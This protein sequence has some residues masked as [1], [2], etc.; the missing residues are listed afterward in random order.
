MKSL[1]IAASTKAV[2]IR[3]WLEGSDGLGVGYLRTV[4]CHG[5]TLYYHP[6]CVSLSVYR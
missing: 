4:D 6:E 5:A 3:V 2:D 1:W